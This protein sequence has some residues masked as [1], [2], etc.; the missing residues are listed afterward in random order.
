[1]SVRIQTEDFHLDEELKRLMQTNKQ[2][3]A[4]CS[5]IGHVRDNENANLQ[6]LFIEH[7]PNMT[8]AAIEKIIEQAQQRWQLLGVQVIHRI[9]RLSVGE[10]IV[11]AVV[12][13]GHR[14]EAF[15]ACEFI[16]DFL[17]TQAPFWKK[18]I[19]TQGTHWVSAR[20]SDEQAVERWKNTQDKA[21]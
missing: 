9:G 5:F 14:G 3:G 19:S 15:A 16:I 21:R 12:V 1:M 11:G 2:I 20:H 13:S 4:S 8:E 7:Y 17:K 10:Q 6:S 18:E